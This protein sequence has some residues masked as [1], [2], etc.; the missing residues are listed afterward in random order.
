MTAT[1]GIV[2]LEYNEESRAVDILWT[3]EGE[4]EYITSIP[5][6]SRPTAEE[7][8]A[9]GHSLMDEVLGITEALVA[10]TADEELLKELATATPEHNHI[11]RDIKGPGQ[12]PACDHYWETH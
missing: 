1:S 5:V 3:D 2:T 8:Q 7:L 11:T 12:C 4:Q 10:G 9:M 6:A